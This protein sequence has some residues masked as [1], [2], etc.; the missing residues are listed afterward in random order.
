MQ[1]RNVVATVVILIALLC[2]SAVVLLIA[3]PAHDLGS[4]SP[5]SPPGPTSTATPTLGASASCLV[6]RVNV[7]RMPLTTKN[8]ATVSSVTFVGTFQRYDKARWST[9]DGARPQDASPRSP[10]A[11]YRP[12][13]FDADMTVAGT[14]PTGTIALRVDGGT[15]GC[16]TYVYDTAPTL[17]TGARYLVFAG[18]TIDASGRPVPNLG[19]VEAWP[20]DASGMVTTAEEGMVTLAALTDE[21][22]AIPPAP[23][24]TLVP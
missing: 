10:A 2:I 20:I 18:Y 23:L 9:S 6:V 12:A 1:G 7:D 8:L 15:V 24:P 21:I 16:D 17:V 14:A 3:T 4:T 19:L 13:R 11:I 22:R 5:T